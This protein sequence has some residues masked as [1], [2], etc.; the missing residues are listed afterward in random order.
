MTNDRPRSRGAQVV[1]KTKFKGAPKTI[2]L[3]LNNA[4]H[5]VSRYLNQKTLKPKTL[6]HYRVNKPVKY[7][8]QKAYGGT[9]SHR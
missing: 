8:A 3:S 6:S 2:N 5:Q 7:Q 9:K 1:K 4:R